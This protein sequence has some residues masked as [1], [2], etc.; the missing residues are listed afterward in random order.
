MY[1]PY[2]MYRIFAQDSQPVIV[3]TASKFSPMHY[4]VFQPSDTSVELRVPIPN[5]S[6]GVEG[7]EDFFTALSISASSVYWCVSRFS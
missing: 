6:L 1:S 7:T 5:D 4:M 2:Q 3:H